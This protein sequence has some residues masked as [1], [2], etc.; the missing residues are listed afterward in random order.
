MPS[1]CKVKCRS[2]TQRHS[3]RPQQGTITQQYDSWNT[4]FYVGRYTWY[5][6]R[7]PGC[8]GTLLYLKQQLTHQLPVHQLHIIHH[9]AQVCETDEQVSVSEILTK[10]RHYSQVGIIVPTALTRVKPHQPRWHAPRPRWHDPSHHCAT[11]QVAASRRCASTPE[12]DKTQH[13]SSWTT[14]Q[15]LPVTGDAAASQ[16]TCSVVIVTTNQ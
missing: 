4:G 12:D 10:C 7:R 3:R 6:W 8:F 1:G 16:Q 9:M 13:T 5:S 11:D 2:P 14:S 15:T